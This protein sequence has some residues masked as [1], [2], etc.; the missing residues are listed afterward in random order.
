MRGVFVTGTDTGVGKTVVAAALLQAFS[1][2]GLK[3]V[4]MKPVASGATLTR[5]GLRNDDALTLQ[6]TANLPRPYPL[7]NPY[8]FLPPVA[9]HIAAAEAGIVIQMQHIL[10]TYQ[11]LC[12]GSDVVVVEGVGGWQVPLTP[13]LAVPDM[14]R[15]L[16]LP[17][18][19]VVGMRLGCLNHALLTAR[20]IRADG[21]ALT[22]WVAKDVATDMA[23]R[24]EN[25][26]ILEQ[27]LD[28]PLLA[29]IP[30]H[31][32]ASNAVVAECFDAALLGRVLEIAH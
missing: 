20:A 12:A 31:P 21:L 18:V 22:G 2:A 28:A 24:A 8:V 26:A 4:G 19:L 10:R 6:R 15:A 14:A 27:L 7:V 16:A 17:V 1:H 13:T 29:D 5:D 11:Q 25:L 23:R 32:G 9:P 30:H 3:T